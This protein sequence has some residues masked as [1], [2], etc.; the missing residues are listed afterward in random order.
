MCVYIYIYICIYISSSS[1]Y[2][3]D[4][5]TLATPPHRSSPKV[6]LQDSTP[7]PHIAAEC[8]FVL[9]VL[10]LHGHVWGVHKSTS[11]MSSSLLLQQCPTCLVRLS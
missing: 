7:Y 2:R 10:L 1:S 6:G 11:L 8:M 4:S 9:V 5:T 3:A